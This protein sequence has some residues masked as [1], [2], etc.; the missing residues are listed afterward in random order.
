MSLG[1]GIIVWGLYEKHAGEDGK[2]VGLFSS[3]DK[4]RDCMLIQP[5]LI[6]LW[7]RREVGYG[8]LVWLAEAV[9][10]KGAEAEVFSFTVEEIEVDRLVELRD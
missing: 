1:K 7:Q 10:R 5:L 6:S 4:A 2:L 3:V 9:D 8:Q